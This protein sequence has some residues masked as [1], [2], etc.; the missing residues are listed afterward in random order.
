MDKKS[1]RGRRIIFSIVFPV[2][3]IVAALLTMR[4]TK[5]LD[6][7]RVASVSTEPKY[8]V[9]ENILASNL[10]KYKKGDYIIYSGSTFRFFKDDA[11]Y[12][13]QLVALEGDTI[14][15]KNGIAYVNGKLIDDTM[16]LKFAWMGNDLN[17]GDYYEFKEK[18]PN[19]E[20]LCNDTGGLFC[21]LTIHEG[22]EKGYKK[23]FYA[24]GKP[25]VD[26]WESGEMKW[27]RDWFGPFIVP[28]DCGF[29][30]SP[31]RPNAFDS[32]YFGPIRLEDIVATALN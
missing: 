12:I 17:Q 20:I 27:N 28:K 9:G 8:S 7:F 32:R 15:I 26:I 19:A 16:Q 25:Q 2:G 23:Y 30:L 31:N 29:L 21:C 6:L 10:K 4:I 24:K 18:N 3:L 13:S 22:V 1:K 14:E 5:T 11:F